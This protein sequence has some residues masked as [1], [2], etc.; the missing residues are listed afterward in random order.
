MRVG[1]HGNLLFV[2]VH[3]VGSNN[4]LGRTREMDSESAERNAA[5]LAWMKEA[6]DLAKRHG[7]KGLVILTQA[8]P[9]FENFWTPRRF[10]QYMRELSRPASTD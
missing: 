7:N 3:T 1:S 8:N 9:V 2:T 5:N 4:N 10:G 6:F